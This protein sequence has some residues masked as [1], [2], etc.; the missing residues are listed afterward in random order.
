MIIVEDVLV[1]DDVFQKEFVCALDSCKGACCW[2]GDFGAPLE[3]VEVQWL[4]QNIDNL[5][6]YLDPDGFELIQTAGVGIFYT[7]MDKI[8]TPLRPDG[9][10]A[11]MIKDSQ[12]KARCGIQMAYEEGEVGLQKPISC[13][14][15]PVRIL[16]EPHHNFIALN[17][18]QWEICGAGC[19]NGESLGVPVF[20]FVKDAIIRRFGKPFYDELERIYSELTEVYSQDDPV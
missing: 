11:Y 4:Q 9:S 17:Y 5:M 8:G 10:C 16:E 13:H 15:F 7:D 2:D 6:P 19:R 12:S 3:N 14:L 18:E 1:S 20:R